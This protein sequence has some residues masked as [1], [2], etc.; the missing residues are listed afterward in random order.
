[1]VAKC[2]ENIASKVS[3]L[4]LLIPKKVMGDKMILSLPLVY[5]LRYETASHIY[6]LEAPCV[7]IDDVVFECVFSANRRDVGVKYMQ[8]GVP[9]KTLEALKRNVLESMD[10]TI[11]D[12]HELVGVVN[13]ATHKFWNVT[14]SETVPKVKFLKE[15]AGKFEASTATKEVDCST[16]AKVMEHMPGH[17]RGFGVFKLKI[18]SNYRCPN[19]KEGD[20]T[21]P[22]AYS[23]YL[24]FTLEA[25]RILGKAEPK[26]PFVSGLDV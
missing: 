8:L 24:S 6:K 17:Y 25:V 4:E 7:T 18:V 10:I 26:V 20:R 23:H 13:T 2:S 14:M 5:D 11:S 15:V 3:Q 9:L 12:N 16:I 19:H 1:M 22:P 21:L